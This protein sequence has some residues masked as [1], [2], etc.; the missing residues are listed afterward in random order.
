MDCITGFAK[1]ETGPLG[2]VAGPGEVG[3]MGGAWFACA[4]APSARGASSWLEAVLTV[5][6]GS[7]GCLLRTGPA[8]CRL[9]DAGDA[10]SVAVWVV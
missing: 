5:L 10:C 3:E 8:A 6:R 2:A 9:D 7:S 1:R 4:A